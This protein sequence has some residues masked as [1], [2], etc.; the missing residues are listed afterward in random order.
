LILGLFAI[1]H[2]IT[3]S[4]TRLAVRAICPASVAETVF[5]TPGL[6]YSIWFRTSRNDS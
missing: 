3:A 5:R 6:G 2:R 1:H 4:T